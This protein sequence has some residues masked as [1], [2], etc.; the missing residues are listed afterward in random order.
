MAAP[1]PAWLIGNQNL[2]IHQRVFGNWPQMLR[3]CVCLYLTITM[4]A[5]DEALVPVSTLD[6]GRCVTVADEPIC[7]AL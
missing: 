3:V 7:R 2:I 4:L 1:V 6:G 5:Q